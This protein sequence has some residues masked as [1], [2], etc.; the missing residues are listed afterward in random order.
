MIFDKKGTTIIVSQEKIALGTF[1][2]NLE[3]A[4]P[5]MANDNIIINLFSFGKLTA[6]DVLEFLQISD[7]HKKKQ[8][9]F[10]L[11][12]KLEVF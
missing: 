2:V 7:E 3:K 10:K 9:S 12:M 4:Y 11:E 1:L 8:K 6:G 5:K